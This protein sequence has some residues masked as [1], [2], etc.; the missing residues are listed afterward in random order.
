MK[1]INLDLSRT[2]EPYEVSF[3]KTVIEN[4]PLWRIL[5]QFDDGIIIW[6]TGGANGNNN[7]AYYKCALEYHGNYRLVMGFCE[8]HTANKAML[9]G[10]R[11]AL[12]RIKK[13][14]KIYVICGTDLGFKRGFSCK[15]PNWE[16]IQE[17]LQVTLQ[18]NCFLT[19]AFYKGGTDAIKNH[20][21][22]ISNKEQA[23]HNSIPVTIKA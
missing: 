21:K 17:V 1:N 16:L 4:W 9:F 19:F 2:V 14:S 3:E 15:G 13:P 22:H 10:L 11:E 18:Q 23:D 12:C 5:T 8:V 7:D 20:L 6:V